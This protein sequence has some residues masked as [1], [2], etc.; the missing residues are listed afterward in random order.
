MRF[1]MRSLCVLAF[2]T[3]MQMAI[4]QQIWDVVS[5]TCRSLVDKLMHDVVVANDV[6]PV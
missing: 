6:G 2:M 3:L 5:A 4:S 1:A